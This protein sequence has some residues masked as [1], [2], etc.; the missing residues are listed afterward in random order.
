LAHFSGGGGSELD[1]LSSPILGHLS[2][3]GPFE[4]MEH[5]QSLTLLPSALQANP[6]LF[7]SH[8][9]CNFTSINPTSKTDI[10]LYIL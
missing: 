6:I 1:F 5:F 7:L 4:P 2:G 3:L 9:D 10:Y 8:L